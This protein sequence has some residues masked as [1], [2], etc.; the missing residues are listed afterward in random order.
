M[1]GADYQRLATDGADGAEGAD[2]T[3]FAEFNAL[4]PSSVSASMYEGL[5]K[6]CPDCRTTQLARNESGT[7]EPNPRTCPRCGGVWLATGEPGLRDSVEPAIVAPAAPRVAPV[8]EPADA[9]AEVPVPP[10]AIAYEPAVP[11]GIA[12]LASPVL[13][14]ESIEPQSAPVESTRVAEAVPENPAPW[15]P[16]AGADVPDPR[17][18]SR[19]GGPLT[20]EAAE[21]RAADPPAY[22]PTRWCPQCRRAFQAEEVEC[23]RCGVGLVESSYR[24]RC[25]QCRSENTIGADACW[26]CHARLHPDSAEEALAMPPPVPTTDELWRQRRRAA[27]QPPGVGSCGSVLAWLVGGCIMAA[28]ITLLLER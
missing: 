15:L 13:R 24:V 9:P 14:E 17:P 19:R 22:S 2:G 20:Q 5:P 23:P 26:R 12:E 8:A 10:T 11:S 16:P 1:A 4:F 27:N 3:R 18:S 6:P 28:L 25:L 7:G 21:E